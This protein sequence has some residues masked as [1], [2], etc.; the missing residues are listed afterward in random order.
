MTEIFSGSYCVLC[1]LVRSIS[2]IAFLRLELNAF[3]V[4]NTN[5]D[6]TQH[7]Q[8]SNE[9]W[10]GP[11]VFTFSG[12]CCANWSSNS[13]NGLHS[14]LVVDY[15]RF[16]LLERFS[17]TTTSK[18]KSEWEW[19]R[20]KTMDINRCSTDV[21]MMSGTQW[22]LFECFFLSMT[23]HIHV[24]RRKW[25][26]FFSRSIEIHAYYS[27]WISIDVFRKTMFEI[28][29]ISMN[30]ILGLSNVLPIYI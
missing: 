19:R 20:K 23:I 11:G 7:Y 9:K 13:A 6:I 1:P 24:N 25:R 10:I 28:V 22:R 18:L 5:M 3:D 21:K 15:F 29:S 27:K 26:F 16:I 8:N 14:F 4:S 2:I 17:F 12:E 30:A